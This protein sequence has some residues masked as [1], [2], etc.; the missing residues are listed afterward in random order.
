M[1]NYVTAMGGHDAEWLLQ[2][3]QELNDRLMKAGRAGRKPV[4]KSPVS[5]SA[6]GAI[7]EIDPWEA[8]MV[9]RFVRRAVAGH[10]PEAVS[11]VLQMLGLEGA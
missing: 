3:E 1:S 4:S 5:S 10:G 6:I 2:R 9:S 8:D 7:R 11:E